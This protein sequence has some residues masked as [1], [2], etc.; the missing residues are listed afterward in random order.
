MHVALLFFLP[1]KVVLVD[2]LLHIREGE[3]LFDGKSDA[4][5]AQL[6]HLCV[7]ICLSSLK[8]GLSVFRE[9]NVVHLCVITLGPGR[10]SFTSRGSSLHVAFYFG[11]NNTFLKCLCSFSHLS[12][13]KK[14]KEISEKILRSFAK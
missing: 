3:R 8:K 7:S 12:C 10:T 13:Y 5:L 14:G 1:L 11:W 6:L 9:N 4:L 2:I